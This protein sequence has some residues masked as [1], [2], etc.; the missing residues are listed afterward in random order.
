[1]QS[2]SNVTGYCFVDMETLGKLFTQMVCKECGKCSCLVLE[3]EPHAQKGSAI[4][5]QVQCKD[6]GRVYTFYTSKKVQ[7]SFD[8]NKRFV[9]AIRSIGQGHAS[10]KRFAPT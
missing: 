9:Y 3:D 7:H 2:K 8:M 10:M 6:F 4:H 5:L 1:M